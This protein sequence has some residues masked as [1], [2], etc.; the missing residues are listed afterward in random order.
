MMALAD[1]LPAREDAWMFAEPVRLDASLNGMTLFPS[2][3][4]DVTS[5]E[6][7]ALMPALNAQFAADQISFHLGQEGR[8]YV[9]HPVGETPV[10]HSIESAKVSMAAKLL[11]QSSGKLNWSAIQNEAQMVLHHHPVNEA[12]EADGKP[13]INGIWFWGGGTVPADTTPSS[14]VDIVA[15]DSPLVTQLAAHAGLRVTAAGPL[16][17]FALP[18]LAASTSLLVLD[19]LERPAVN[20]DV[21]AWAARLQELD[22]TW[23]QRIERALVNGKVTEVHLRAPAWEVEHAFALTRRQF[24][25]GFWRRPKPLNTYA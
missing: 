16:E 23:F 15:T 13:T 6:A 5:A 21:E 25:F 20:L 22:A 7:T 4:L 17:L 2:A 14:E 11:P 24:Q 18:E 19:Q 1:G 10:T 12:R 8:W 3:Y 9:R